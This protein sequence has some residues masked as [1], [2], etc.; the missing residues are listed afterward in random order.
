MK[1]ESKGPRIITGKYKGARLAVSMEA[2][3]VTDRVKKTIFDTLG[4]EIIKDAIVADVFAGSGNMGIEA[5]SQG[6]ASADF[7][8]SDR[9]SVNAINFNIRK[10][11]IPEDQAKVYKMHHERFLNTNLDKKYSLLFVDPPFNY[12]EKLKLKRF[13]KVMDENSLMVLKLKNI[14]LKH[15]YFEGFEI[16]YS[17]QYGANKVFYLKVAVDENI[18]E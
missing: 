13:L 17:K 18:S 9:Y 10:L 7:I 2:R 1:V 12:T 11:N 16:I 14:H 15:R 4:A 6:A 5:L 8:D 3:P